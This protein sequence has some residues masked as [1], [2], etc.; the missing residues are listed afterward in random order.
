MDPAKQCAHQTGDRAACEQRMR[1]MR[2]R[3]AGM[4]K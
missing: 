3:M 1:E 2:D 4:C